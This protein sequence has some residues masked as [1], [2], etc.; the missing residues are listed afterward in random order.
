[1]TGIHPRELGS[2]T[3]AEIAEYGRQERAAAAKARRGR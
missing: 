2:V 1:M 3:L